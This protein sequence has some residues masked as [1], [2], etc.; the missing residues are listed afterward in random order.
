MRLI[1]SREA[2]ADL[3]RLR[4]FIA[5]HDPHAAAR[6]AAELVERIDHLCRFPGMG[7][8]VT[9][10]PQPDTVRDFTFGKYVARY[11]VHG[12]TLVVL[13]LWHRL[14]HRQVGA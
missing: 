4:A 11:T 1:Y 2:V 10:A 8:N 7:R 14:E 9:E 5:K 6:V 13:R 12:G 3:V